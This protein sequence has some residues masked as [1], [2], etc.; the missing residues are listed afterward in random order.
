MHIHVLTLF[1]EMFS[2]MMETSII[3]RALGEQKATISLIQFRDFTKDPYRRVD[4]PPIGGGAGLVLKH[5]PIMDAL[6]SIANPGRKILLTPR[7]K[8]F[9]QGTAVRLSQETNLT[10][11]CGHYEGF[12]ERIHDEVD[13]MISLG[14]FVLTGG[15]IPAMA[16]IDAVIRLQPGVIDATSLQEESFTHGL[17][18]YPQYTE[19]RDLNGRLV[20]EILYSGNHEAIRKWRLKQSL[21]LTRQYRPDL[22]KQL[23]LTKEMIALIH[24]LDSGTIGEWETQAI[25][26][27]RKFTKS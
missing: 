23:T 8:P 12:D 27:G 5:Q 25:L 15:E 21:A 1:P 7:G 24:E 16:I 3:K 10:F 18:E 13:E 22:F 9:D 11:I 14:D 6:Q 17:L 26:K 19:P 2:G 4:T 20:P